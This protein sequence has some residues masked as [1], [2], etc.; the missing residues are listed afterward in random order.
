[1]FGGHTFHHALGVLAT[2]RP[3]DVAAV[4]AA[5]G[6]AH[7]YSLLVKAK[8]LGHYA[9]TAALRSAIL[10]RTFSMSSPLI[11]SI[12]LSSTAGDIAPDWL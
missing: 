2:A 8:R 10:A 1:M 9:F 12:K 3:G 7:G 6:V 11:W 4:A 5:Y